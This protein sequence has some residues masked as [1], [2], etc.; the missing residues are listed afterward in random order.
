MRPTRSTLEIDACLRRIAARQLGLV[1]VAQAARCGVDKHALARRRDCGALLPVYPGVMGLAPCETSPPQRA[2]AASLAVPGSVVAASSA[3]IVHRMPIPP[4]VLRLDAVLSVDVGRR[5]RVPGI[6]VVRQTLEWPSMKWVTSRVAT[7]AA[8][9]VLLPRFVDDATVER[10][11]DH[12]LAHRLTTVRGVSAL[13]DSLPT[14]AVHRRALL[15]ELLAARS[16]GIG[17]RSRTEQDVGRWLTRAGLTGWTRNLKV[18]I[19]GTDEEVEV[20]FGWQGTRLA[21]E[22][23]PFFTHGSRAAQERDAQ[24]RRLLVV[25]TWRVVEAI[26]RDIAHERAFA[27]TVGTLRSLGAT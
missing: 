20:D 10:C 21:L 15:L 22:V 23:S 5:V 16:N 17:H 6:T 4:A 11:F 12:S 24:R 14:H 3:A 27:R 1:T 26:D 13:I 9:L 18:P 19:V 7:P 8:T 25:S 2:L